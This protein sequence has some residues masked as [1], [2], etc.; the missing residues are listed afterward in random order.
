[1]LVYAGEDHGLRRRPNQLDYQRRIL[2]WFGH[3]LKN[4]PAPSWITEGVTFLDREQELKR[5]KAK[6]GS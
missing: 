2:Q 1:M 5:A 3:Y 4:E 6:K